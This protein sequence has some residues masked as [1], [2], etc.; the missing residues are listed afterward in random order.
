MKYLAVIQTLFLGLG[1]AAFSIPLNAAEESGFKSIF[2]GK[3]L[4]GW[5]GNPKFWSVKDGAIN[6]TT[7]KENPTS[8]NTFLI[9]RDGTVDDFVLRLKFKIV[10]GNSGIQ[11]RSKDFGNWVVGG[12]Q[13]DFEAGETFSGI[14]YEERMER[15]IMAQR[16]EKVLWNE[17]GKKEVTGSVG[18]SK[19][20]QAAIKKE[21]WNDYEI[22]AQG[23]HLVHKINGK[24]TVEVL[25]KDKKRQVFSGILALQLH[26]GPP[27]NVQFKD[28]Q[29]KRT[30]L[31]ED[32]KKIV[33]VAGSPSHGKG[34]HEFNAG[35]QLLSQCLKSHPKIISSFY[36]SGWPKD[37]TAFDNA[38]T[39]LFFA[40]GGGGHPAIQ[41]ERLKVLESVLSKGVG[42][43]AVHYGV[44]VP[45]E[46]G[47]AEFLKWIGGYFETHWSVNP[48]W[49]A[50]FKT[51]PQHPVTSGVKPF[52]IKDEWY[53]H[54][55]FQPE[56]NGVTPLLSAVPPEETRMG[57]DGPHSGNPHVRA[58]KGEA[59]VVSWVYERPNGGRGFGFTGAH[60]HRNWGEENFRKLVL[61]A[62]VWTAGA[63]V[64]E[65]GVQ[66]EVTPEELEKNLDPK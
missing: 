59:E 52:K 61:N 66:C 16:G 54:M 57:A 58:R 11:Y 51:I 41:G 27:M 24:T 6:G 31:A 34:D 60:H 65:N 64:P 8:G 33:M 62:L 10:G 20:I 55:R 47:G 32:K 42:M 14:L 50:D 3:D 63:E 26:A 49:T 23:S 43:A 5:D 19:E 29:L 13:A 36:L 21:D 37:P 35:V 38:D 18:D 28:I 48:H 45:K 40:D 17:E 12:Y 56:M 2:N 15:G 7:T 44:E 9:W 53:Y 39:I 46:K 25:D 4:S 30:R 22:I 1:L